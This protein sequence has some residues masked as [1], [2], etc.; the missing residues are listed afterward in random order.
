MIG[1]PVLKIKLTDVLISSYNTAGSTDDNPVETVTLNFASAQ[2]AVASQTPTGA[3]GEF[4]PG[5][6]EPKGGDHR[7]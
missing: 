5:V 1:M 7:D 4:V 2:I 3:P 6:C